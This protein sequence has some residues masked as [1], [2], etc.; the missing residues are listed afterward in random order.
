MTPN[1]GSGLISVLSI[2]FTITAITVSFIITITFIVMTFGF[3]ILAG[4][5][6]SLKLTI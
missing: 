2:T 6:I 1:E 5:L 3:Q 4:Y